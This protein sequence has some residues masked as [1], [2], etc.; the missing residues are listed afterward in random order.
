MSIAGLLGGAVLTETT[1]ALNGMGS[2]FIDAILQQDYWV[3][4]ALVFIITIIFISANLITDVIYAILDP[5][6]RYT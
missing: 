1:F 6:I 2:L 4:D 3:I 5:R